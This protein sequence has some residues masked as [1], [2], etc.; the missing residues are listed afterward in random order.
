MRKEAET[1]AEEDRRRKELVEA[2]NAAD[3]AVYTAEK[4]V[5]D[6]GDKVPA[7]LKSKIEENAANVRKAMESD[8]AAAI[9]T[10]TEELMQLVQQLGAAAYQQGEPQAAG[11]TDDGSQSDSGDGGDEGDEDV[12][13]GEFRN[14]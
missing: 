3:N 1:H 10:A 14:V 13:E 9:R 11:G 8:D 12:V 4:T 5:R 2:R 7:D 6:L